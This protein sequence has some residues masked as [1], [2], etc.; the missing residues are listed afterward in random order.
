AEAGVERATFASLRRGAGGE[1]QQHQREQRGQESDPDGWSVPGGGSSLLCHRSSFEIVLMHGVAHGVVV[2][3][4]TREG[5]SVMPASP[6][7]GGAEGT[8]STDHRG[9]GTA[10]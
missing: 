6:R 5:G 10:S 4:E 2:G 9:T 1:R 3:C 7:R 8:G